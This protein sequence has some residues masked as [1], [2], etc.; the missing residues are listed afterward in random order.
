MQYLIGID[1]GTSGTKTVLFDTKGN[2]IAHKTVEYPMYQ[3]QNGWAE[4]DPQDWWNAAAE[5]IRSVITQ[6]GVNP[7][8]IRGL[9]ISGQMHGLV[10]LDKE[11]KVLRRSIIWCDQ[12][13]A[14]ECEELTEK[15]GK[16]RLIEITANPA[17]TGFTASKILW[18]RNHE[19]EIYEKCAHILLP[20]DYVRYELT[21][22]FATEV[23]DASGMQLLDIKNRCW[24][25]EVL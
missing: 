17:M 19:P 25:D 6:S 15:V 7:A 11:G 12:R 13:T 21:G 2:V 14:K 24:S 1:L 16:E 20:K 23:S 5:T 22:E 3:P 8:D 4:Q 10:M 9:G 18:V